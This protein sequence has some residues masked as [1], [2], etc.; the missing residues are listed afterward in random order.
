MLLSGLG[1][2][3]ELRFREIGNIVKE[4]SNFGKGTGES[5]LLLHVT[6]ETKIKTNSHIEV[7]SLGTE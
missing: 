2:L 6:M 7:E 3:I 5:M 4:H 1:R